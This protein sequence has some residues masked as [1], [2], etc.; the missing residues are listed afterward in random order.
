[1]AVAGGFSLAL[2]A[3]VFHTR[4][5]W[6]Y[7]HLSF[8]D[9][10]PLL[11]VPG[12]L[13][14]STWSR[15]FLRLAAASLFFL[16]LPGLGS[17]LLFRRRTD[18]F[19]RAGAA[20]AFWATGGFLLAAAGLSRPEVLRPVSLA[21]TAAGLGAA[22]WRA[23]HPSRWNFPSPAALVGIAA[24]AVLYLLTSVVP[25]IFYDALVYHLAA[26]QAW[27]QAG[28]LTD[29]PDI[30]LW[31]L[32]G[33]LQPLYLWALAWSDDRLC[34]LVTLGFGFL[35][36]GRLFRWAGRRWGP[37]VG[38]WAALIFLSAPMIGI[39]LWSC[40]NDIPAAFFTFLALTVWMDGRAEDGKLSPFLAG[41]FLGA[42][43]AVKTTAV[44]AAPFFL[45]AFAALLRRRGRAAAPALALFGAGFLLPLI[46]WWVRTGLLTGNP[47]FPQAAALFHGD[48]PANLALL[49]SWKAD[50]AGEG[51]LPFR[52]FTFIRDGIQG[53][54]GGR[55]GFVGPMLVMLLP[56]GFFWREDPAF[57]VLGGYGLSAYVAFAS[58]SGRLRY[59]I[60]HLPALC[61]LAGAGLADYAKNVSALP[62]RIF[63][64]FGAALKI[65]A[66]VAVILNVFWLASAF[67][68]FD[69]GWPVVWGRQTAEAYLKEE[70]IG[71]YGNPSEGAFDWLRDNGARGKLFIVGEA[72]TFRSPLPAVA[73]GSFNVPAYVLRAGDPPDAQALLARLREEGFTHLLVNV[74]EM[75]RITPPAYRT[76][77]YIRALGTIFDGAAVPL[78][79]YRWCLL[80]ALKPK[81]TA[82]L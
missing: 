31:R 18:A 50:A 25:D 63:S 17:L 29:M 42:G 72:R 81:T 2:A 14:V 7:F 37:A 16:S 76:E 27:L 8:Q 38:G 82:G 62:D 3:L 44:F 6:T 10:A 74:E 34:K 40:A 54:E 13:F 23:L 48:V 45:L 53:I 33:L 78:Y 52:L 1:M 5:A 51:G 71:V 56:L 59:F 20:L 32:P 70:H 21:L 57:G 66:G 75:K 69:Q 9:I 47:F 68:R 60:P 77:P 58:V 4:L 26:P 36:A 22:P 12:P 46:P 80:F 24:C 67:S 15:H 43:T 61:V 41:L 28:R 19:V 65:A 35:T 39:N 11:P 79:R 73:A 30:H 55:F 64:R 49:D